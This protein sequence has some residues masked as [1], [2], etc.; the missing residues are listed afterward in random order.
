MQGLKHLF[1]FCSPLNDVSEIFPG[2]GSWRV[3]PEGMVSDIYLQTTPIG[4][5]GGCRISI[6]LVV[7]TDDIDFVENQVDFKNLV[8]MIGKPLTGKKYYVPAGA[9][10]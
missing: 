4:L 2:P 9:K 5:D 6:E 1:Y 7:K 10:V 3:L 8:D